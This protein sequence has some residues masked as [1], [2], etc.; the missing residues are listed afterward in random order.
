MSL[1]Y[2]WALCCHLQELGLLLT[3]CHAGMRN[4]DLCPPW[5]CAGQLRFGASCTVQ[6]MCLHQ[7]TPKLSFCPTMRRLLVCMC[8]CHA[9]ARTPCLSNDCSHSL[10]TAGFRL[11]HEHV[12]SCDVQCEG[13]DVMLLPEYQGHAGSHC[14]GHVSGLCLLCLSRSCLAMLSCAGSCLAEGRLATCNCMAWGRAVS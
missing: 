11:V 7:M 3:A 5:H 12:V 10:C 2:W 13:H 14:A 9:S 6:L 4:L 8:T 1:L